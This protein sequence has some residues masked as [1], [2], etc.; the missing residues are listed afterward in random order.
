MAEWKTAPVPE[1]Q[2]EAPQT[3]ATGLNF[4]FADAFATMQILGFPLPTAILV[5]VGAVAIM[6]IVLFRSSRASER[7]RKPVK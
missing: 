3:S 6:L 7:R 4:E 5:L 2:E 1:G